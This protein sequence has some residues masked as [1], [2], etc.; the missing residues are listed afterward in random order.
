ML[1]ICICTCTLVLILVLALVLDLTL[2]AVAVDLYPSR[3]FEAGRI[4]VD[5]NTII[6]ATSVPVMYI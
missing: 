3:Y 4:L 1:D 6:H 5:T 2:G